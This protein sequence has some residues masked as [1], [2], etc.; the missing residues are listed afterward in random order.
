MLPFDARKGSESQKAAVARCSCNN[1][2]RRCMTRSAG[3]C[4]TRRCTARHQRPSLQKQDHLVND[5]FSNVQY[6]YRNG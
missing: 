2:T 3:R 6:A 5:Q 4:M 1:M